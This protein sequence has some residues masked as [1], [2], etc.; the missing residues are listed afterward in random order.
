MSSNIMLRD[1]FKNKVLDGLFTTLLL[2]YVY[3]R[4][5][6]W[7]LCPIYIV[8]DRHVCYKLFYAYLLRIIKG[9]LI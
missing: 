2:K 3:Y 6:L 1:Y 5:K 8:R 4:S 7:L 9:G